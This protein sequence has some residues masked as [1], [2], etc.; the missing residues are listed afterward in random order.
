M[1]TQCHVLMGAVLFGGKVPRTAWAAAAGG[2]APDLPMLA[3]VSVLRLSGFGF[4]DIFGRLYW[5]PWWQIAN[6]VGH[7]FLLWSTVLGLSLMLRN[8]ANAKTAAWS[9][10]AIPFGAAALLHSG[11]DFLVHRED[12]HMH[13]WPLTDWRFVSPVSYWDR[14]HYGGQFS[15]FEAALGIAMALTLFAR[16]R[17]WQVRAALAVCIALY[18][19]VPVFFIFGMSHQ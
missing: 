2:F 3:I 4:Q 7:N 6:A 13:F 12:A 5:S 18:A 19:A 8:S 1:N 9:S 11:A 14:S 16:F 15:L 10:L 17:R